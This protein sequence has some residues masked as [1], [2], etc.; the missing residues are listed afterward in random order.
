MQANSPNKPK[1]SERA[2]VELGRAEVELGRT[3][4][5]LGGAEE[6]LV[7]SELVAGEDLFSSTMGLVAELA[8]TPDKEI[9]CIE[10][11]PPQRDNEGSLPADTTGKKAML[12]NEKAVN[13]SCSP[14]YDGVSSSEISPHL[15]E[16]SDEGGLEEGEIKEDDEETD[17]REANGKINAD[18]KPRPNGKSRSQTTQSAKEKRKQHGDR[19]EESREAQGRPKRA[20]AEKDSREASAQYEISSLSDIA[21]RNSSLV[22]HKE[23]SKDVCQEKERS[24]DVCQDGEGARAYFKQTS[25]AKVSSA[26]KEEPRER[27]VII[28]EDEKETHSRQP[29]IIFTE[30]PRVNSVGCQLQDL[31]LKAPGICRFRDRVE[32]CTREGC[33]FTHRKP[34]HMLQFETEDFSYSKSGYTRY[35]LQYLQARDDLRRDCGLCKAQLE[36]VKRGEEFLKRKIYSGM[37]VVKSTE[38]SAINPDEKSEPLLKK[39]CKRKESFDMRK[40]LGKLEGTKANNDTRACE[41]QN[42]EDNPETDF[43][44]LQLS[45]EDED[46]FKKRTESEKTINGDEQGKPG[47]KV[48]EEDKIMRIEVPHRKVVFERNTEQRNVTFKR[49]PMAIQEE[50]INERAQGCFAI[51]EETG[52]D[53]EMEDV[54][55]ESRNVQIISSSKETEEE[56]V[57]SRL[58]VHK[59]LG[60]THGWSTSAS[61]STSEA[62]SSTLELEGDDSIEVMRQVMVKELREFLFHEREQECPMNEIHR[63]KSTYGPEHFGSRWSE[64]LPT[65]GV[66]TILGHGKEKLLMLKSKHY[67]VALAHFKRDVTGLLIK[68]GPMSLTKLNFHLFGEDSPVDN[69]WISDRL[70]G[71]H[72]E[73]RLQRDRAQPKVTLVQLQNTCN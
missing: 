23:K 25:N 48:T 28:A 36:E 60:Q 8:D 40:K 55:S 13:Q 26:R 3:E 37:I 18:Y 29:R 56:E 73:I 53:Q 21:V 68:H 14:F 35:N 65:L 32:G 1:E 15:E 69:G 22:K 54:A 30:D 63:F 57:G 16:K 39:F 27:K 41:E 71:C 5:E 7:S 34:E 66:A 9:P 46:F 24:K 10:N 64:L 61:S 42:F 12:E 31:D 33:R 51:V 59:R 45:S 17:P 67:K 43:L 4:V 70:K 62:P 38:Q 11:L 2:E 19:Q 50:D 58:P 6:E 72:P 52:E 49:D 44:E 20:R 47:R